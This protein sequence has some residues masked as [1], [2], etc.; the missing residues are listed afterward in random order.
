VPPF[1]GGVAVILMA[2][3]K[4]VRK[5][6]TK[7]KQVD[8]RRTIPGV[9]DLGL[10]FIDP[11]DRRLA[12]V[13]GCRQQVYQLHHAIS[14]RHSLETAERI[15][16]SVPSAK[17]LKQRFR[18]PYLWSC[19]ELLQIQYSGLTMKKAAQLLCDGFLEGGRHE[20]GAS[21]EAILKHLKRLKRERKS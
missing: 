11:P 2:K 18:G 3:P 14:M 6:P 10:T 13:E 9:S 7:E 16:K 19:Y 15:F 20:F 5:R 21:A 17:K 4:S 8:A 12:T 1:P